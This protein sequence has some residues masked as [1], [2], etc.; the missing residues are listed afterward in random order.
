M[1]ALVLSCARA[2]LTLALFAPTS[3]TAQAMQ[4][5]LWET[6][7]TLQMSPMPASTRTVTQCI[8]DVKNP[9][10]VVPK[11]QNYSARRVGN[12]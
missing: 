8:T 10:S 4:P 5:G 1:K 9:D 11:E 3:A 2:A 12:C 6:T 7:S